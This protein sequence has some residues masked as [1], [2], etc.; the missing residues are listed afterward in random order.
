MLRDLTYAIRQMRRA[1][2][3]A[4]TVVATLALS[5]GAATAVFCVFDAVILR[6]LPFSNPDRIMAVQSM[7]RSGYMQPAS[8]QAY[9][10]E[11]AQSHSF[12]A[13]AG[14]INYFKV[15]V[16]TPDGNSLALQSVSG[17]GNFFDIFGVKPLIGR[18]FLPGEERPGQNDV[19]VLSFDAWQRYFAGD[20]NIVGRTVKLD[21]RGFTVIG[22]MPPGFSF[23]LNSRDAV[24]TPLHRDRPWM[25]GRGNHWLLTVGRLKDGV[26]IRQAQADLTLV[27]ANIGKAYPDTDA[28]RTVQ[29]QSLSESLNDTSKGPLWTLLGAVL[30]VL[31]IGCVNVAGLLLARGVKRERE[32]AMRTAIGAGRARLVRQLLVEGVVLALLGA[33]GGIFLGW[34]I[35]HLM[36]AF[37]IKALERG[38]EIHLSPTVFA[39]AVAVAVL[40]SLLAS[41]FPAIRLSSVDPNRALR[42]GGAAGTGRAQHR[43]RSGFI[44]SQMALTM[45][46]L[47]VAGLLMRVLMHYRHQDLGFDP[48]Y[49]LAVELETSHDRYQNRDIVADFYRPLFGRVASIPGV[50]A[51]GVINML[52][53][54]EYGSNSDIHIAGQPPNPPNREMLAENRFVS[55]GYFDVFQIPLRR[56]RALSP[57]LDRPD[58]PSPA[59]VVN[60]SFVDKFIPAAL[61][62]TAQRIDDSPKN[63]AR[64]VGVTGN[65]RQ[66]IY[67]RPLAERDFLIDEMPATAQSIIAGGMWLV[68]RFDGSVS[69]ILPAVRGAIHD[70]DPT[71]PVIAPRTMDEVVTATLVFERMESWLFGI[72]AGLAVVLA[73]VGLYGL[74]SHE[75][76]QSTRDI[77]VRMALGASRQ[78]ILTMILRRVAWMLCAG[79]VAGLA[80]A[81]ITRKVI[82]MVIYFD[83]QKE[84]GGFL[85]LAALLVAAGLLAALIP[86]LRAA[87]TDPMQALRTE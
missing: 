38:A 83:A 19:V 72:F 87:S 82:Y 71:V 33:A 43:L 28:G 75:V 46:L 14:Y 25:D 80:L 30:A 17:T 79:A 76:E 35:L 31:L 1:P 59:M 69:S 40:V 50:R 66:D 67:S 53:I 26:T 27:F 84:A 29:V 24:Y 41:V 86:G 73:L 2:G 64:I 45:V 37:L 8:W 54:A 44:V 42:S 70:I 11:R 23:P 63:W 16:E 77:G 9:L 65:V 39:V 6:P 36:R 55:T 51:V 58:N 12:A 81:F 13:L 48:R 21:G 3:F 5:V 18:T 7:S 49:I 10:D 78:G 32:M 47:I 57:I 52:P 61:D 62:P 60:Q 22:V 34:V 15:T 85:L 74:V 56:G 68:L 20:R 4:L